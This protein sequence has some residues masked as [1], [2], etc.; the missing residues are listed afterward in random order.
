MMLLAQRDETKDKK[1][2]ET[3]G[4]GD[5]ERMSEWTMTY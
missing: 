2:E 4:D 5:L 3:V 1:S